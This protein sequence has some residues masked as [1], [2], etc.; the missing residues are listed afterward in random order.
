MV[1]RKTKKNN[2]R[3]LFLVGNRTENNPWIVAR[4]NQ[5]FLGS[6]SG[7]EEIDGSNV[8]RTCHTI[9]WFISCERPYQVSIASVTM[10]TVIFIA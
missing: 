2:R 1:N 10:P 6:Y 7:V 5:A 4:E 3:G 9:I 8:Q